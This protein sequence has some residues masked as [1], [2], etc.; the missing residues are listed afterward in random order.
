[1]GATGHTG[2]RITEL[3]RQS[4]ERV[5]ALGRSTTKLAELERQGAD[6]HAGD[7]GDAAFLTEA[8]LG[9]EAAYVLLP[10]D[11]RASDYRAS[12]ARV[13][14]AITAALRDSGVRTVVLL[15]SV[16]AELADGTGPIVTLHDFEARLRTLP[17]TDTL[18]LR[19]AYFFEN[20]EDSLDL[21][22]GQ[23]IHANAID[24]DV[25]IPMIATRDIAEVAAAALR[26]RDWRGVAIRELLG[27]CDL[28]MTGATRV[29]GTCLG[30]PDLPYHRM[31]Y[32]DLMAT[33]VQ[34]G[35]SQDVA[36]ANVEL[37]RALNEGTVR[38]LEGRSPANTTPTRFEDFAGDL[39]R[40]V[41][42]SATP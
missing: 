41:D 1:M 38:S 24:P 4:G 15:S 39:A 32:E 3:L 34:V 42:V 36:A 31:S 20:F 13:A 7:A 23:G 12:Q 6:V 26:A 33:L 18:I 9:V 16:G 17:N 8:F 25:P 35:L 40:R 11:M 22:T 29:L 27:P 2:K 21:I 10:P 14:E 19:A 37:C 5:R 28:T 30:K